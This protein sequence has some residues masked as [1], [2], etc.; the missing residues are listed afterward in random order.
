V[1]AGANVR[2]D[3]GLFRTDNGEPLARASVTADSRDLATLT[4]SLTAALL[5]DVWRSRAPPVPSLSSVTTRSLSALQAYL[6]GERAVLESRWQ[7]AAQAYGRAINADSTFWLAYWRYVYAREWYLN[8][9]DTAIL[10]ALKAHRAALP[11][12]DR[13]VFE[14]W[15]TDTITVALA[16]A[17]E[18]VE[19]YPDYWPGW[20]VYGDWLF[21]AGPV[22]G[23]DESEAQGALERTVTLNPDFT[24]AW[25]HLFWVTL[26][27]DTT[28]AARA[29]AALDR[30]EFRRSLVAEFGFDITRVYRLEL[31]LSRSGVLDQQLLDSI[32][33]DL[34]H[35]ARGRVGGGADLPRVQVELS[36]RVLRTNPRPDLAVVHER[37]LADAWA[38]RGAWDSA[39]VVA[40]RLARR[41][42]STDALD[43]YRLAVIGAWHGAVSPS[44]AERQ[45]E[46]P[47]LAAV[48][49]NAGAAFAAELAWLD[50][51]L[52][53]ARRDRESVAAARVRL[54]RAD[55]L[56]TPIL[57][58]SLAALEAELTGARRQAARELA[59]LNWEQP[60]V[61][62]PGYAAHPYVIAFCRLAAAK[63]LREE[64]DDAGATRAA[65]WFDAAWALDGSGPRGASSVVSRPS[66]APVWPGGTGTPLSPDRSTKS[67]CTATIPR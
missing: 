62:A 35:R 7:D 11:E 14:S 58:R 61:L 41:S 3:V 29:L 47:A 48:H 52:A 6:E 57:D 32:A 51:I 16:R 23:H 5:R 28:A 50:G 8:L 56:T 26:A 31:T 36:R 2:I 13:L 44:E 21:H 46:A 9:G 63:W 42:P 34:V 15:L 54:R 60:D 38:A 40:E 1:R 10:A 49:S 67:S 55:T 39:L 27:R 20:M 12:R 65:M 22:Y 25:E 45:R 18:A 66:N 59:T 19:R 33:G 17:R 64:G 24:A 43:A 53:A 30:L 4:D 37:L